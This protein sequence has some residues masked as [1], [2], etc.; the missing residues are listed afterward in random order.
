MEIEIQKQRDTPLLS[1]KR[2][3]AMVTYEGATPSRLTLRDSLAKKLKVD[4][5]LTIIKHIYTRYGHTRAKVIAHVYSNAK[6]RDTIE[7]EY[8][9][10]KHVKKETP[11]EEK[12]E[13]AGAEAAAETP[14]EETTKPAEEKTAE[15][16]AES[17]TEEKPAEKSAESTTEEKPAEKSAESP[18]NKTDESPKEATPAGETKEASK[19]E[20][21]EEKKE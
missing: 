9:L 15:K 21:S 10:K 18:A 8:L 4:E 3:S 16:S 12:K 14:K 2:V 19:E 17:T 13:E 5:D 1:R 11:K 6:D 7:D 20:A